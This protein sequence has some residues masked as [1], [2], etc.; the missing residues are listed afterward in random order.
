MAAVLTF[1]EGGCFVANDFL[2]ATS[3]SAV[4][5]VRHHAWLTASTKVLVAEAAFQICVIHFIKQ[6]L[7]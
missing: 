1:E 2:D 6:N 7:Y 5:A 4:L 3:T